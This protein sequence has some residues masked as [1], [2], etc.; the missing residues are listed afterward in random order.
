MTLQD[1]AQIGVGGIFAYGIIKLVL[2]FLNARRVVESECITQK[3]FGEFLDSF[4]D[5]YKT[6]KDFITEQTKA[7]SLLR[8]N[9][10]ILF[11]KIEAI[12]EEVLKNHSH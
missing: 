9:D 4:S 5:Y 6:Q 10:E 12:W 2:D 11:K 8:T 7:L 1:L 3:Q